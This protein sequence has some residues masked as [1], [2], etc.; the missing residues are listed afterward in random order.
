MILIQFQQCFCSEFKDIFDVKHF[1]N[2][3]KNDIQIVDRLPAQYEAINAHAV[4]PVSWSKA[5]YYRKLS[6]IL[7][8]KKVV[9]FSHTDSRLSNNGLPSPIQKLRCRACYEALRF[10]PKI[11][12]LGKMIVA[13]LRAKSNHYVALHLRYEKDMLAFTGCNHGLTPN[14]A[15]ELRLIRQ[16]VD[17]W[18]EKE[19]DSKERRR[20]GRCPMTPRET[21]AFLKAMGY[22]STTVIYIAAG[23]IYGTNSMD[24]LME[25]YPNIYTHHDL[26]TP[27]ELGAMKA[28]NNQLAALDYIVSLNSD[29][30][31]YTHNGNMAKA[32]QGHRRYQG[33]RKTI[34]PDRYVAQIQH[35]H[36]ISTI[37]L[38]IR[39]ELFSLVSFYRKRFVELIDQ[40][41]NGEIDESEFQDEVKQH[42][43]RMNGGPYERRAGENPKEEENFYA[44][45]LPGCICGRNQPL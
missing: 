28:L 25:E 14:Q 40:L 23:E 16:N 17:H 27:S 9:K 35:V 31:I 8:E 15:E 21:A 38:L 26:T 10:S 19:I 33:F 1:V 41:D 44:N 34:V 39:V 45:P 22:P 11:E 6:K 36:P 3:L 32:V 12:E 13:R 2:T 18:K 37:C 7:K 42:H 24:V 5:Y 29:V 4:R 30:F 20:Q 43:A